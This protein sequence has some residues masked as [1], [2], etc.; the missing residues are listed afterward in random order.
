M[1]EK[2]IGHIQNT[3]SQTYT[4]TQELKDSEVGLFGY[5]T[6]IVRKFFANP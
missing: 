6:E 5:S 3:E 4:G 2:K 1:P